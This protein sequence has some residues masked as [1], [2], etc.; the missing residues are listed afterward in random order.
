MKDHFSR[1]TRQY[2]LGRLLVLAGLVPYGL[3]ADDSQYNPWQSLGP[4]G[5]YVRVVRIDPLTPTTIYA[6]LVA[7]DG[8]PF[9]GVYKSLD[10]GNT[11]AA[12][13]NGLPNSPG[14]YALT[15]D[16]TNSSTIYVG[17]ENY[18]VG[19]GVYKS[20]DG[21]NSWN[22]TG[23]PTGFG[24][25]A[26]AV[27]PALPTT[28]YAGTDNWGLWSS[29]DGGMTWTN[30]NSGLP[31]ASIIS[32]AVDPQTVSKMYAGTSGAGLFSSNDGGN[33]W[34]DANNGL[35]GGANIATIVIKPLTTSTLYVGVD[36]Y[37]SMGGG[38]VFKSTDGANSWNDSNNGFP[39]NNGVLTI[40]I[41]PVT[42]TNI[43]AASFGAGAFKSTDGGNSWTDFNAG[44]LDPLVHS[45]AINPQTPTS[46]YAGTCNTGVYLTQ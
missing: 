15:M 20:T 24:V 41:D 11:W 12:M 22:A 2:F 7:D 42:L 44:L 29:T 10:G 25:Y 43:Y 13:N 21:G 31:L 32:L 33:T 3:I 45:I 37:S 5:T 1:R 17:I 16:P 28:L 4:A 46:I 19:G 23:L 9:G 14:I 18:G 30:N 35:P 27:N 40:A 36:G 39:T 6:G 34:N 38:G 26:V 8:H